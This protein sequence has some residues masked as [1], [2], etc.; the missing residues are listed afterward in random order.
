MEDE[1]VCP[2]C[3][4]T[5]VMLVANGPDDTDKDWCSCRAGIAAQRLEAELNDRD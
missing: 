1:Y 3:D 5:G 2:K 4:N